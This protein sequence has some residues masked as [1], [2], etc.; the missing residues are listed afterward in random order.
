MPTSLSAETILSVALSELG[1]PPISSFS[2]PL[3]IEKNFENTYTIAKRTLLTDSFWKF[4]LREQDLAR[5]SGHGSDYSLQLKYAYARPTDLLRD[6]GLR[7]RQ[8][9]EIAGNELY[10]D[11]ARPQLL[12]LADVP[13]SFFSAFFVDALKYE[14]AA[15]LAIPITE[16]TERAEFF[17]RKA[18][19]ALNR[20]RGRDAM[21]ATARSL[22]PQLDRAMSRWP[23]GRR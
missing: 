8:P 10:T 12:Y 21:S 5:L 4:A 11:D 14:L 15:R 16:R 6:V 3:A 17:E 18:E 7:S 22:E 23:T 9:Y 1:A 2:D 19:Q 20:A 13:E